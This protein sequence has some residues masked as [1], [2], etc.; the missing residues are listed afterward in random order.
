MHFLPPME[1]PF[2]FQMYRIYQQVHSNQM[3]E[4]DVQGEEELH[5]KLS[6]PATLHNTSHSMQ[7]NVQNQSHL[8]GYIPTSHQ[9]NSVSGETSPINDGGLQER[10]DQFL[11]LRNQYIMLQKKEQYTKATLIESQTKWT[12]FSITILSIAKDV[13]FI[14]ICLILSS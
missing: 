12:N 14:L 7:S 5:H 1:R 13:Y 9:G 4:G 6:T 10:R 8:S 2:L 11:A 3:G